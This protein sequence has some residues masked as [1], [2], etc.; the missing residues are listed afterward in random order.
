MSIGIIIIIIIITITIISNRK[1]C[2]AN[3]ETTNQ[4]SAAL[5]G[6]AHP[7]GISPESYPAWLCLVVQPGYRSVL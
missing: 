6:S 3:V 4:N 7:S 5:L 2:C 1:K